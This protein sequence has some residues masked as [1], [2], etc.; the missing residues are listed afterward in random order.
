MDKH[1][2]QLAEQ[3]LETRFVRVC[4]ATKHIIGCV[5]PVPPESAASH[6]RMMSMQIHAEKSPFLTERLRILMLPTLALIKSE[7]TVDYIVGFDDLG[8]TDDFSTDVLAARL[9]AQVWI[10]ILNHS[11][12][13][14]HR[15]PVIAL[16]LP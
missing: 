13:Q 2:Q 5:C 15:I 11:P 12:Q 4:I 7:K 14:R 3:H 8:G 9:E 16:V 6:S 1:L 10:T